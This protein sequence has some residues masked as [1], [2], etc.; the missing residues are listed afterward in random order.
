MR[1]KQL[2]GPNSNTEKA[3][4]VKKQSPTILALIDCSME[5]L[6]KLKT[7]SSIDSAFL[8]LLLNTLD[9]FNTNSPAQ[10]VKKTQIPGPLLN[11]RVNELIKI[12]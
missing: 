12:R 5:S 1:N 9:Q 8:A 2:F 11:S 4:I 6:K 10:Q 7:S 3:I